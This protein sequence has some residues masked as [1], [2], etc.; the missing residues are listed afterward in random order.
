MIVN[1]LLDDTH[2][3]VQNDIDKNYFVICIDKDTLF[4]EID[5]NRDE[6]VGLMLQIDV[7]EQEHE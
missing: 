1:Q 4:D 5:M 6:V 3:S 2:W 7:K